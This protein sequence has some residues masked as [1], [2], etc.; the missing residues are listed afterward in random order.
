MKL[1]KPI[2]EGNQRAGDPVPGRRHPQRAR[3]FVAGGVE[4]VARDAERHVERAP[5][6]LDDAAR[7]G[8]EA[9]RGPRSP[10]VSLDELVAKGNTVIGRIETLVRRI[11]AR[12]GRR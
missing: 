10:R 3:E 11:A 12:F 8:T 4:P 5:R 1:D 7:A 2:H 6:A 9:H